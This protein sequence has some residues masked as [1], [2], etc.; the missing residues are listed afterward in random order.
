MMLIPEN[1]WAVIT[2]APLIVAR[3]IRGTV[4]SSVKRV[5]KEEPPKTSSSTMNWLYA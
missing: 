1:C 5:R 3:R 2:I 4:K